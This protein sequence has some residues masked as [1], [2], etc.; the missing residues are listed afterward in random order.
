MKNII[1]ILV[2]VILSGCTGQYTKPL[3]GPT[4][5]LRVTTKNNLVYSWV[6]TYKNTGCKNPVAM[7]AIGTSQFVK[8]AEHHQPIGMLGGK[9]TVDP[10]VVE[11]IIPANSAFTIL[12]TQIGPHTDGMVRGCNLPV[13]FFPEAGRQYEVSYDFDWKQCSVNISELKENSGNQVTHTF[14]KVQKEENSCSPF[15]F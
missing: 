1:A 2:A 13:T 4:A 6:H 15:V 7:G 12:F 5:K 9:A 11:E 3:Q 8:P 10:Q 14:V